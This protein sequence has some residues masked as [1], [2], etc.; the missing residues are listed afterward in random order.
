MSFFVMICADAL[1]CTIKQQYEKPFRLTGEWE[2]AL[3]Y[4]KFDFDKPPVF[5]FCNLVD[6]CYVN[7]TRM[8]FLDTI[9]ICEPR[10]PAPK[11]VKVIKKRFSSINVNIRRNPALDDLTSRATVTCVQHF[12]KV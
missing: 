4:L 8:Q 12:R 9:L 5:V 10:N 6:Y 1:D 2:V 11:Y 3:T 7:D